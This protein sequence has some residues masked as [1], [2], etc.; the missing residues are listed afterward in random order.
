[1]SHSRFI[2]YSSHS[3]IIDPP[4]ENGKKALSTE[5]RIIKF[6]FINQS[7]PSRDQLWLIFS[8]LYSQPTGYSSSS[9]QNIKITIL[10]FAT[11][12]LLNKCEFL[13]LE[14]DQNENE[15]AIVKYEKIGTGLDGLDEHPRIRLN[16]TVS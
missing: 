15:E 5:F 1:M 14:P 16:Q 13:F 9:S 12:V 7:S 2:L 3:F 8:R 4:R 11:I 6:F 10:R